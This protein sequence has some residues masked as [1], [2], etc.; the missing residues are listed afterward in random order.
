MTRSSK[1][2]NA[3][4][5]KIWSVLE[6]DVREVLR[7]LEA[8]S[9]ACCVSSPPYWQLR[10]YGVDGQIGLE[11]TPTAFVA[12][13][14]AVF[15][16]VR[17]VLR[18]DGT[19]WLN[20]G[21][22]YMGGRSGG[23]TSVLT[24][25]RNHTA[26]RAA[27]EA[28]STD[29]RHR[30]APG[31][32]PKDLVGIPWRVAFALQADGWWL[33]SDIVWHKPSAMPEAVRDRPTRAHEY[34]FLLSKSAKYSYDAAAIA[35]PFTSP[36]AARTK[37]AAARA[38]SRRRATATAARQAATELGDDDLPTTRNKRT[39]WTVPQE[40]VSDAHFATF[41]RG[42]VR[43]CILAGAPE[44]G[45]VL[46][47]FAGRCTTGAVAIDLGRRFLGVE[48]NPE[49][50]AMGRRVLRRAS[51]AAGQLRPEDIDED[52]RAYQLGLF[53]GGR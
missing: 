44:G 31:L 10:D 16:E 52:D 6:G 15:R 37:A 33:R 8:E 24:S 28:A 51:E 3:L 19:L 38:F 43:P 48:V 9:V 49:Y 36:R 21:D 46:D 41:P 13:L 22:T 1:R 7:S 26:A 50:A 45:L 5:T 40:P 12:E 14:V 35:E 30:E 32:K 29:K 18:A 20:L 42:L 2:T 23:I 53:A 39:V 4:E 17:R 34:L 11:E 27:W 25:Q 47:P